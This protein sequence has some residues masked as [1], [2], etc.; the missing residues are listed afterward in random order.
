MSAALDSITK[1]VADLAGNIEVISKAAGDNSKAA[2][3]LAQEAQGV[4]EDA[5]YIRKLLSAFKLKKS[6]E[7]KEIK[8]VSS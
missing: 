2:E 5:E 4:S 3:H 7:V 1:N 8:A 6:E